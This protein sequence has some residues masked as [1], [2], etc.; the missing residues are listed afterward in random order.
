MKFSGDSRHAIQPVVRV[1]FAG[2]TVGDGAVRP[3]SRSV[4]ATGLE[5][6]TSAV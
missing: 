5:P 6:V 4:G 3:T 2:D 1:P